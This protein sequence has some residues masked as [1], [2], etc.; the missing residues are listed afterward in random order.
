MSLRSKIALVLFV[1]VA[2]FTGIDHYLYR[3]NFETRFQNLDRQNAKEVAGGIQNEVW[4]V[5]QELDE[6]G[7]QLIREVGLSAGSGVEAG[8]EWVELLDASLKPTIEVVLVLDSEG[9]VRMRRL[10]DSTSGEGMD[11]HEIPNQKLGSYHPLRRTDLGSGGPHGIWMTELGPLLVASA[12]NWEQEGEVLN[13]ILGRFLDEELIAEISAQHGVDIEVLLASGSQLTEAEYEMIYGAPWESA[14]IVGAA[15]QD[16]IQAW[17]RVDDLSGSP[18][19]LL[20]M[21]VPLRGSLLW[22]EMQHY[23]LASTMAIVILFPWVILLLLQWV[24]TG[25]L[26]KLTSHATWVSRV[27]DPSLR[28][29]LKRSDEIGVLA[30]EFDTMLGK[31]ADSR[32]E[33]VRTA[34]MAGMSEVSVGVMHNVGNVLTSLST[35]AGMTRQHL[36]DISVQD[37]LR[38]VRD[39]LEG[40]RGQLDAYLERDA[41]GA[42]LMRFLGAIIEEVDQKTRL[43]ASEMEGLE[44]GVA[45]MEALLCSLSQRTGPTEVV[46]VVDVVRLLDSVVE[47][48]LQGH[49]EGEIRVTRAYGELPKVLLDR[50]KL[51]EVLMHLVQNALEATEGQAAGERWL[52]VSVEAV[53]GT[54]AIQIEDNGCG[55]PEDSL[56]LVFHMGFSTREGAR[57]F[58][59]HFAATSASE[60]GGSVTASSPGDSQGALLDVQLPLRL[61]ESEQLRAG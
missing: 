49:G 45:H 29:E 35:S 27:D 10:L 46:E 47:L 31:L 5:I 52:G 37:D 12:A 61:P 41:Q 32:E 9:R 15:G 8:K 58:G 28:L 19:M 13:L 38:S 56:E 23:D 50:N 36:E 51:M 40:N 3:K 53:D 60:L 7:S 34:R 16:Q 17:T 48:C 39:A 44:E 21:D 30:Q 2:A 55:I 26:A 20:R 4:R 6:T 24:V 1:A 33:V 42:H 18:A 22:K 25:P 14:A 59:L 11:M 43:A 54:L 57:G